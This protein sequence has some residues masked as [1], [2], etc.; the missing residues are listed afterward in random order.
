[1]G[2]ATIEIS[3]RRISD[4]VDAKQSGADVRLNTAFEILPV[5]FHHQRSPFH[6]YVFL[7]KYSGTI[8]GNEFTFRKCYARGC[9]N[10]LCTHVSIA[11][12]IANRYL[13]RD[14]HAL[15]AAGIGVAETLF[16]LDD[17]VVKFE[18]LKSEIPQ[19][20]TLLDLVGMARAGATIAMEIVLEAL[21][22]VEHFAPKDNAQTF[23]SGEFTAQAAS[24]E[25]YVCYRCF[26]CY[27]TSAEESEKP[28]AIKVAN[29]RLDILYKQFAESSITCTP[30]FFA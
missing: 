23:L 6:A 19:V 11:V 3:P 22:A 4:L 13:Q 26:A 9:P 17:M 18:Q 5:D 14:Y 2:T 8:D 21:P 30:Q 28:V 1:M 24:G 27:A 7:A 10:N 20:L 15:A 12:Q 29:A 16:S 25:T